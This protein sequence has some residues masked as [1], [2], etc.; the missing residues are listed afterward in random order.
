MASR[1]PNESRAEDKIIHEYD[2]IG[3]C[4]HQLPN[5]WV[6]TF[7]ATVAFA[8]G[9]FFY[10]SQL[11]SGELP[12]E[13]YKREVAEHAAARAE[14]IRAHGVMDREALEG[15]SKDQKSVA[16]GGELFQQ[17]CSP[18]HAAN[19]GGGIGPNLTDRYWIHG[20]A[21]ND[22]YQTITDG[23]PAKGMAAWGGQ[24]GAEAIQNVTAFVLT[25]RNTNVP[26]GKPPQGELS[27]ET[28]YK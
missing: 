26:D 16:K 6:W 18:C 14:Q 3:E 17:T 25:L 11:R 13:A 9:Y 22:I 12:L 27:N 5:W 23:V 4:D 8:I 19:G 1:A 20:G 24:L 2:G 10:Y 7:I 15:L 21:P 28:E